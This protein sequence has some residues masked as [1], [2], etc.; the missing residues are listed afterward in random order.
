MNILQKTSSSS[1]EEWDYFMENSHK[2]IFLKRSRYWV[3]EMYQQHEKGE[4]Q[5]LC[6]PLRKYTDKFQKYFRMSITTYDYILNEIKED[7]TKYSNFRKC[8][9]PSERLAVTVR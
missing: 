9:Y 2:N 6:L 4:Y 1:D 5:K 7:I 3:H 8:V